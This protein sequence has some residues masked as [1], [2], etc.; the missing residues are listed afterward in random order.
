MNLPTKTIEYRGGVVSLEIPAHWKEEYEPKG[1]GTFYED[2]PDSGTLRLNV[3]SFARRDGRS[4]EDTL[5][6]LIEKEPQETLG[7][8]FPLKRYM[9]PGT[10][11]GETLHLYRWEVSVPVPPN[12]WRIVCF[13]H[14]IVAGQES[15]PRIKCELD[16]I[17]EI[18]RSARFSTARGVTGDYYREERKA[19]QGGTDNSGAD[20]NRSAR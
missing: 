12:E 11:N 8:G 5:R 7:C 6:E 1:G 4:S 17:D 15:D 14:T 13:V 20:L 16:L 19:Q 10:E 2:R 3:L 9:K 18:V